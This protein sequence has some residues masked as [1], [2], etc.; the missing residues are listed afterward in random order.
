LAIAIG[1]ALAY[2]AAGLIVVFHIHVLLLGFAGAL[3]AILLAT[4]SQWVARVVHV[5]DG[6][7]L[8]VTCVLGL[9]I[10]VA[11]AWLIGSRISDQ[12]DLLGQRVPTMQKQAVDYLRQ[13]HIGKWLLDSAASGWDPGGGEILSRT[14]A[15]FQSIGRSITDIVVVLFV[16][17][18][19]AI[20]P[21]LYVDGIVRLVPPRHE[22]RAR[23]IL[24]RI[25]N[26]LWW[27]LVGQF[28]AMVFIG[29]VTWIALWAFGLSL[30][31]SLG[32]IAAFLNFIPNF[33]PLLA[34]VPAIGLA[35]I[36]R[37]RAAPWI[38][39]VYLAIQV[40]QN[41]V[42]TPLVQQQAVHLSPV[43]LILAQMFMYYWAGALGM[44]L[45][46]A[47]AVVVTTLVEMLYVQDILGKEPVP[48]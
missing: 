2:V 11:S 16:G 13:T 40:V 32:V 7:A 44:L 43:L 38:A 48:D 47:L 17:L 28:A 21:R 3:L 15:V 20:S 41:H 10:P 34:V 5:P 9:M 24:R 8:T 46:P 37:P 26:L 35:I 36:E 4:I 23:E 42:V 45:A 39:L 22:A 33:G 19:G 1:I 18:F 30:A 25:G 31:L 29:V 27:W 12:M 6:A 14:R